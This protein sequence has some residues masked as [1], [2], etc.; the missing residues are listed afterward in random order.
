MKA[1][2][3]EK[4][5]GDVCQKITDG[6]HFSPKV[7]GEGYPYITVRDVDADTGVIDFESCKFI[8][9]ASFDD[10]KRNGCQP[11]KGDVLFSKDGTV[12]KVSLVDYERE[13]VVLSSLAIIRPND[14]V[15]DARYLKY[16]LLSSNFLKEAI[17]A[18][19]GVAIRRIVLRNLKKIAIPLP[20]LEEQKRIV[21][22]L[23]AAF[24]GLDRARAHV[25]ANLQNARELFESGLD[26]LIK[27][28]DESWKCGKLSEV[29]GNVSTGPFG[30]LL[31]KS[32]YVSDEIPIVNPAHII[33]G[34][35]VPDTRKTIS[36]ETLQKLKK[37]ILEED[38]IVIGRRGDMGRC[39]VVTEIE[40]GWLCG[41]GS[42]YIRPKD[43][44]SAEFVAHLL[45]TPTYIAELE[46]VATG[47]TML[48]ISNK[49]LSNLTVR[50]PTYAVQ[51]SI[52]ERVDKLDEI[53][54]SLSAS[55]RAKLDDLADLRQSLLQKAFA[56]EL[57]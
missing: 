7:S 24:E 21:A 57:T 8:P 38:D 6:S 1:G 22:V 11:E 3:E 26:S 34:R 46:E 17:G 10:L 51:L 18:K 39:A 16:V 28:T 14:E 56:G 2:W 55:Y 27:T 42:F 13:F 40:S 47:A 53:Q 20:P 36:D 25:E 12:G 19:T 37:Y 49:S 41:T 45:R 9:K 30:S 5:L 50:V 52:L 4:P 54:R 33:A 35:I 48:N 31:H 44:I 32:D 15:L 29:V 23:D 43:D